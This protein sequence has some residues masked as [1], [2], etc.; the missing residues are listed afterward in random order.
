MRELQPEALL[1]SCTCTLN[2]SSSS[3][4]CVGRSCGMEVIGGGTKRLPQVTP[5]NHGGMPETTN[6]ASL[7]AVGHHVAIGIPVIV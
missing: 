1:G 4:G 7:L 2:S 3:R 5:T 6:D